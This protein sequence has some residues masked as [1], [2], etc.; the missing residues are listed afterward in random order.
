M[1]TEINDIPRIETFIQEVTPP[2]HPRRAPPQWI[3]SWPEGE[4]TE[5]PPSTPDPS[6]LQMRRSG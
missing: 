1:N 5:V 3:E 2:D 4:V 6:H